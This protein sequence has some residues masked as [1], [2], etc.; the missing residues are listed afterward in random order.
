MREIFGSLTS[1][2]YLDKQAESLLGYARKSFLSYSLNEKSLTDM[3]DGVVIFPWAGSAMITAFSLIFQHKGYDVSDEDYAFTV[4]DIGYS[5]AID[6]INAIAA[7]QIPDFEEMAWAIENKATG[8][9]DGHLSNEILV[10][11]FASTMPSANDFSA[12]AKRILF[13]T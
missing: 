13:P 9:Y 1:F 11:Q 8:K 6:Q 3:G 12:V 5:E 7:G 10:K 4:K 2:R